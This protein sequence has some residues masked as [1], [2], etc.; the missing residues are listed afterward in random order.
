M[1]GHKYVSTVM[2]IKKLKYPNFLA[3]HVSLYLCL[4]LF[5][6]VGIGLPAV[7]QFE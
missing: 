3:W 1:V 2:K 5:M 7:V 4:Y 6:E